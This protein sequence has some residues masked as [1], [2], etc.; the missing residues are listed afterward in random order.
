MDEIVQ[1]FLVE[2]HENLDQLDRD[3]VALERDP[4]SRE[5]L[6]SVFR[7]IHTIK[8]TS[9]FLAFAELE[10]VTHAGESL[11]SR[12]RDGKLSL[13]ADVTTGLLSMV[14]AVRRLLADI[15]RTGAE[16]PQDHAQLIAD[17]TRLQEGPNPAAG[18]ATEQEPRPL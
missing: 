6:S 1:E 10:R 18:A 15:E 9:G 16:G 8:G 11:L 13:T 3:L 7:T 14:D 5:R 12:L 2:S 17:L 4:E